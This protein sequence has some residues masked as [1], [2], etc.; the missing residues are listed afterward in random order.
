MINPAVFIKAP[1]W[2]DNICQVFPPSVRDVV[3]NKKYSQYYRLLTI[4]NDD[5]KD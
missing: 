4:T 2:F 5:I 3:S 1:L